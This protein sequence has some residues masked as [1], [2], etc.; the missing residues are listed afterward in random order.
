MSLTYTARKQL[1][2]TITKYEINYVYNASILLYIVNIVNKNRLTSHHASLSIF[3]A[4]YNKH[5]MQTTQWPLR[6]DWGGR[7]QKWRCY[8]D[9][10]WHT[11]LCWP[12]AFTWNLF[13]TIFYSVK[14][15]NQ[16]VIYPLKRMWVLFFESLFT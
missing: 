14:Q 5:R 6:T 9:N 15:V 16:S 12:S 13:L 1:L 4:I 10:I 11:K 8:H 7:I 2:N 3:M